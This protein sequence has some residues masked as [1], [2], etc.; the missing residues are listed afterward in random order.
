MKRIRLVIERFSSEL[1]E[2]GVIPAFCEREFEIEIQSEARVGDSWT[3]E[4][5]IVFEEREISIPIKG[6]KAYLLFVVKD[7]E[8]KTNFLPNLSSEIKKSY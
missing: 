6:V 8:T 2:L 3:D 5:S 4:S 7:L 1:S